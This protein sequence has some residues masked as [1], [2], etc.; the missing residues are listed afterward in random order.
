MTQVKSSALRTGV[1]LLNGMPTSKPDFMVDI[2]SRDEGRTIRAHVYKPEQHESNSAQP[3]IINFHG[4]G[5]VLPCHGENDDYC[6]NMADKTGYTVIDFSYRLAPEHPFPSS[7]ND[8]ED[9]IKYALERPDEYDPKRVAISGFSAGANMALV[10]AAVLF[11][12]TFTTAIAFYPLANFATDPVSRGQPDP[13]IRPA[14]SPGLIAWLTE[15]LLQD[16]AFDLKDPRISP[17]Y[18]DVHNF[19]QKVL[20]V[21]AGADSLSIDADALYEKL[22]HSEARRVVYRKFEGCNHGWDTDPHLEIGSPQEQA[23]EEAHN[24][25]VKFLLE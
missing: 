18:A 8:V 23:K 25:A 13:S 16:K 14:L 19:P 3:V 7:L 15:N 4:S 6:R 9:T 10:A 20:L 1:R 24:L 5:W 17:F 11:P 12:G 21:G 2:P 22:R